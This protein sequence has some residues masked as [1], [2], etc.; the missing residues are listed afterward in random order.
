M[1]VRI[2]FRAGVLRVLVRC[3]ACAAVD[4]YS[5]RDVAQST[6]ECKNCYHP[7]DV[8]DRLF[9]EVAKWPEVPP[10]VV[11]LLNDA[12]HARRNGREGYLMPSLS[13]R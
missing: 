11:R 4:K 13:I 6:I 10:E 1:Q 7:M 3:P 5:A 12:G 8:R 9:D 2:H